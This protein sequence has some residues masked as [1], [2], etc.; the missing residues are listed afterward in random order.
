MGLYSEIKVSPEFKLPLPDNLGE[1]T[2]EEIYQE[3]FQTKD[4]EY[5]MNYYTIHPD[6]SMTEE[7]YSFGEGE[8]RVKEVKTVGK[9]Q[10]ITFYNHFQREL[11]DYW[12]EFQYLYDAEPKITL[13]Q[14]DVKPNAERKLREAK[15]EKER[16]DRETLLNKWY[17]KPYVWYARAVHYIFRKYRWLAQKLPDAWQVERFL[18]PL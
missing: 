7:I 8:G 5:G 1:L 9:P 10:L 15:W 2:V 6:G 3:A 4:L 17:M 14:F 12:V 18:T 16:K 11:S 13:A